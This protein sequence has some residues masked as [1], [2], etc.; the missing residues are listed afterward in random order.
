[1]FAAGALRANWEK[2]AVAQRKVEVAVREDLDPLSWRE[3]KATRACAAVA[4]QVCSVL[5]AQAVEQG[6]LKG[7]TDLSGERGLQLSCWLGKVVLPR[8]GA[9]TVAPLRAQGCLRDV[10]N[11]GDTRAPASE[12]LQR[13]NAHHPSYLLE[14]ESP[15]SKESRR[16]AAPNPPESQAPILEAQRSELSKLPG[17]GMFYQALQTLK[18]SSFEVPHPLAVLVVGSLQ[19]IDTRLPKGLQDEERRFGRQASCP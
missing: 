1:V 9:A 7:L 5:V 4:V 3:Q 13:G 18:Q 16:T 15:A 11:P 12:A 6:L 10:Q 17:R 8:Q 14:A 2:Q 19:V